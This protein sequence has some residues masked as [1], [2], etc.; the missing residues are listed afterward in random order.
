MALLVVLIVLAGILLLP[1]TLVVQWENLRWKVT[2]GVGPVSF[3]VYPEKDSSKKKKREKEEQAGK[4]KRKWTAAQIR[5]L[6]ETAPGLVRRLLGRIRRRLRVDPVEIH[7]VFRGDDPA[8][9][10]VTYG[11]FQALA[12]SLLPFLEET[13][14]TG[15]IKVFLAPE[16]TEGATESRGTIGFRLRV[17]PMLGLGAASLMDLIRW[18]QGWK[19]LAPKQPVVHQENK[20]AG[21]A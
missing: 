13:V 19:G 4:A 20:Q 21:E 1:L 3:Q 9:I 10:A 16:F 14:E 5:Y 18:Y 6:V 17:G 12:S 2:A 11:R 8:D 15:R 7:A